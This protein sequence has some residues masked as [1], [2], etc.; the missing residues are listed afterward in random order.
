MT[1][2]VDQIPSVFF[3]AMKNGY[4]G[5]ASQS[6]ICELPGSKVIRFMWNDFEVVDC[7]FVIPN[8]D[9]SFGATTIYYKGNAVWVMQYRG[10]YPKDV[11]PFLKRSLRQTYE[12]SEFVGGRGPEDYTEDD[13]SGL[14]YFNKVVSNNWRNFNGREEICCDQGQGSNLK[15]WHEYVGL[16]LI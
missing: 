8:S 2:S 3:A 14:R 15:G 4:V 13:D 7:Y 9:Y 10:Q 1:T 6:T 12:K 16:L 11:I 5:G